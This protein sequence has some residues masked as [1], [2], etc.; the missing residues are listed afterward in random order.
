MSRGSAGPGIRTSNMLYLRALTRRFRG[1]NAQS[2]DEVA[3]ANFKTQLLNS[4]IFIPVQVAYAI[5]FRDSRKYTSIKD[6][7]FRC[8]FLPVTS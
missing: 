4:I 8:E 3:L 5:D 2:L 7:K 6:K 1:L